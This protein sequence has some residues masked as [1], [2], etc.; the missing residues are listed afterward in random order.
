MNERRARF[1]REYLTDGNGTRAAM[2][3]GYAERTA[4]TT[5]SR[6]LRNAEVQEALVA[7]RKRVESL[8]TVDAAWVLRRMKRAALLAL[9]AEDL[10]AHVRAL[11]LIGRH[12]SV[13]AWINKHSVVVTRP[14]KV[15]VNYREG[16]IE[17]VTTHGIETE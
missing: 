12:V 16:K 3:A 9:Q 7:A 14:M 2:R 11:D 6:L 10:G 15:R 17:E 8:A 13:Q 4:A 1:V 5:A